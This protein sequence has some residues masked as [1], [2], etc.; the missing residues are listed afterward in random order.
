MMNSLIL[1]LNLTFNPPFMDSPA[2][3]RPFFLP[4]QRDP[5]WGKDKAYH[6][7][8]SF[9]ICTSAMMFGGMNREQA[10]AVTIGIGVLKEFYD[11]GI[12]KTGFSLR[13]LG[14]DVAGAVFSAVLP[15]PG[16]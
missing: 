7:S 5:I 6:F 13:D 1:L 10:F 3:R 12:K 9:I 11:W 14:Y 15:P 8:V 16:G 2:H 4:A